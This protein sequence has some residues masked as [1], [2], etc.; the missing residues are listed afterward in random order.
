MFSRTL[1]E[2]LM[3]MAFLYTAIKYQGTYG[4]CNC[5][6]SL[7]GKTYNITPL[8]S[9]DDTARLAEKTITLGM[10]GRIFTQ[11]R[12]LRDTACHLFRDHKFHKRFK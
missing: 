2:C 5:V 12:K 9:K 3:C 10:N 7:E 8:E 1:V 11:A 4:L 6:F